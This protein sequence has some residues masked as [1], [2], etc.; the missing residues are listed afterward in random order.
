MRALVI[1][2]PGPP[3]V[4]AIESRPDPV[5]RPDEVVLAVE[6]SALNRADLLQRRGHYP[7]P[8]GW[9]SDIPGLEAAGTIAELGASVSGWRVGDRAMALLGG[10]GQAER[11]AVPA[12]HL[13]PIPPRLSTLEAAAIPEAFLT[14]FDALVVQAALQPGETVLI[15][16]AASGIGTAAAQLAHTRSA[17][18]IGWTRDPGKQRWLQSTGWFDAV[19]RLPDDAAGVDRVTTA[20]QRFDVILDLIGTAGWP[21]YLARLAIGGRIMVLGTLSGRTTPLDLNQLMIRRARVFGSVL[22]SRD[23][24]EKA[25]LVARARPEL[26]PDFASGRLTPVIDELMPWTEA[27]AAHRR[28]E[29]NDTRGKLVLRLT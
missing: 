21:H 12:S 2:K 8:P 17:R 18:T 3:E 16:A 1:Q 5:P 28:M 22:R 11:V 7:A 4:L 13:L 27:A 14:A 24:V 26:L 25:L 29:G 15:T 23:A 10:G 19:E 9:P 6:A 20:A